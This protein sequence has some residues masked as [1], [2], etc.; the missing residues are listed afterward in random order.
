[1]K[2]FWAT[3]LLLVSKSVKSDDI[4]YPDAFR[5]PI[6]LS[7]PSEEQWMNINDFREKYLDKDFYSYLPWEEEYN[8]NLRD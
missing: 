6:E 4:K 7:T 5:E 1:M 2:T 3:A 8:N